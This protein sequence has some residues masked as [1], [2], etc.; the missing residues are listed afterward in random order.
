MMQPQKLPRFTCLICFGGSLHPF[1]SIAFF[2][3][4]PHFSDSR[5][6]DQVPRARRCF[7]RHVVL[8]ALCSYTI[9]VQGSTR[10]H[11]FPL[12]PW[13]KLVTSLFQ[14]PVILL[15]CLHTH[16]HTRTHARTHARTRTRTH[17]RTHVRTHAQKHFCFLLSFSASY[18]IILSLLFC[19]VFVL[20]LGC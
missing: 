16:T 3:W 2:C 19:I 11:I 20:A 15:F 7:P 18:C 5:R 10:R 12:S 17:A 6:E 13:I 1:L 4:H 9:P 14:L 8:C